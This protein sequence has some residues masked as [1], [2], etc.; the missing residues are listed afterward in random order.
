MATEQFRTSAKEMNRR[1]KAFTSLVFCWLAGLGLVILSSSSDYRQAM[2]LFT[3][4]LAVVMAIM[5][6]YTMYYLYFQ[7]I[8]VR[9]QVR[10]SLLT[11]SGRFT[12][13]SFD[14]KHLKTLNVKYTTR[15]S[16][17]RIILTPQTGQTM[18]IDGLDNF[19][20]LVTKITNTS[21]N[22]KVVK[23]REKIDYD[24]VL[25]YPLFS[26]GLTILVSLAMALLLALVP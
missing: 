23:L 18:R 15:D 6:L 17:R 19:D 13:N 22:V 8:D 7:H 11:K 12:S 21:P 26:V 10:D 14:L 20:K 3:A 5:W 9:V 4:L 25:F 16:I 2:L 24:H 1:A